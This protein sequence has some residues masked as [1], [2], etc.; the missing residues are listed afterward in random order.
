MDNMENN[1]DVNEKPDPVRLKWILGMTV[2]GV[3]VGYWI[4]TFF[5]KVDKK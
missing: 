4:T 2:A 3:F 1:S 5:E